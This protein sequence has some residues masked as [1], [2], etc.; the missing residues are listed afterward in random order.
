MMKTNIVG[1]MFAVAAF[2]KYRPKTPNWPIMGFNDSNFFF[3]DKIGQIQRTLT[4][5]EKRDLG[6][7]E[8]DFCL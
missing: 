1:R 7:Y 5:I 8:N 2:L 3:T 6:L 4:S